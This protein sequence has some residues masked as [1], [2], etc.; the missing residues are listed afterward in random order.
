MTPPVRCG[1]LGGVYREFLLAGGAVR[2][3]VVRR[4]D[5]ARCTRLCLANSVRGMWEATLERGGAD[6]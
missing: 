5:L 6:G 3:A 1:L 2:E 4:E